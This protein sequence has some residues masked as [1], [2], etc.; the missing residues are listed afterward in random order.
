MAQA[1]N[2]LT[3]KKMAGRISPHQPTGIQLQAFNLYGI[4]THR[5]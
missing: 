4:Y 1:E 2:H 3:D 5:Q